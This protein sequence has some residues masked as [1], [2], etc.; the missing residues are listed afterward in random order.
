M[1]LDVERQRQEKRRMLRDHH[2]LVVDEVR[3]GPSALGYRWSS[4]RVAR[5]YGGRMH[6]GSFRRD[7]HQFAD[8]AGCLVDHPDVAAAAIAVADAATRLGIEAW[9]ERQNAGDLRYVWLKTNGRGDVFVTLVTASSR[10]RAH[11]LADA[12]DGMTGIAWSVQGTPGNAMRGAEATLLRGRATIDVELAGRRVE[13]G[14]LG[15]LQPNPLVAELAYHDLCANPPGGLA[16]DLY[17]GAGITTAL[18]T[19]GSDAVMACEAY[20]ESA[21][22]LGARP[23]TAEAFLQR[24]FDEGLAPRLVVANPPRSGLGDAV[25][26]ALVGFAA[27]GLL[28]LRLMSCGPAA[29]RRDLD[30]LASAFT[31]VELRAYDTLPHTPHVEL[32]AKLHATRRSE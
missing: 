29:L 28:E 13:V 16:F 4:K 15:F 19:V 17:A 9:D 5:S 18:L 32:V 3:S 23:E 26:D 21:A 11:E 30:R 10:T 1:V 24:T 8:M 6:L 31:L 22:G 12:L 7:S 27:R 25:C 14:P 2:G 20:A